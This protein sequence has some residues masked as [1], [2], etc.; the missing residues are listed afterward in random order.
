L[1]VTSILPS[2]H[3]RLLAANSL[4]WRVGTKSTDA[5]APGIQASWC[6]SDA[7]PPSGRFPCLCLRTQEA[8]IVSWL[9]QHEPRRAHPSSR[10]TKWI[11]RWRRRSGSQMVVQRRGSG[12]MCRHCSQR[13]AHP[14][15]HEPLVQFVV[16]PATSK[17]NKT[18]RPE[19][20]GPFLDFA[21]L[22][23]T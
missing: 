23:G 4:S 1:P 8:H 21:I 18:G 10:G 19:R 7:I 9:A 5:Q 16:E 15:S 12:M 17:A 13:A 14:L 3:R 20:H 22:T 2:H 6:V 11:C